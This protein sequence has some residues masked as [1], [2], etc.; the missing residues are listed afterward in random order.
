MITK[1]MFLLNMHK[2]YQLIG[3]FINFFLVFDI[4]NTIIAA[5]ASAHAYLC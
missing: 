4:K 2:K 1:R 5:S 3:S